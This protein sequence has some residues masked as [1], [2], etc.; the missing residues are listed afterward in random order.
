MM[1][2][3][4]SLSRKLDYSVPAID[5]DFYRV[6]NL[7]SDTERAVVKRVRDFMER[8]IAPIIDDYWARDKFP[9]EVIPKL[10]ALEIGGVGYRGYGSAGGSM[11]LN[12]FIAM[13]LARVDASIATFWGVH[14]GLAAGSIYL[15][16]DEEQKRRWLPAMMRFDKIGSFGLTEPL[17]GSAA[18][19]G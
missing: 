9:F 6:A 15:C 14:T 16:G 12:G 5:G 4:T 1:S 3:Q 13:E 2:K 8:E 11:L 10:A 19:A 7:L 18:S 17:V